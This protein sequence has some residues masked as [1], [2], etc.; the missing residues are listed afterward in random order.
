MI[1]VVLDV[2]T[3]T[4]P[5]ELFG[6]SGIVQTR[7]KSLFLGYLPQRSFVSR[8]VIS[9]RR[10]G[11]RSRGFEQQSHAARRGVGAHPSPRRRAAQ[12]RGR[13]FTARPRGGEHNDPCLPIRHRPAYQLRLGDSRELQRHRDDPPQRDA[14]ARRS[15][16]LHVRVPAGSDA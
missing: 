1:S 14:A 8:S 15:L 10:G 4:I 13:V 16:R 11:A 6:D 12:R 7:P 5:V 2:A 9:R 3:L